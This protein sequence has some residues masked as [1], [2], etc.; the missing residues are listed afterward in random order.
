MAL[1]FLQTLRDR[2][3]QKIP[4]KTVLQ[5]PWLDISMSNPEIQ[6]YI[7]KDV[8]LDFEGLKD[9]GKLYAG[10]L[11]LKDPVVSPIYGNLEELNNIMVLVSTHELFYPDCIFLQQKIASVPGTTIKLY[12]K[13]EMIHDWIIL[14][15][16]ERD[17]A[18]HEIAQFLLEEN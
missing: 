9:C 11:D 18:I 13:N 5:S 1:A 12:A 17:E 6:N 4:A 16:D 2:K 15:I 8:L 3:A 10:D 14:P 7:E